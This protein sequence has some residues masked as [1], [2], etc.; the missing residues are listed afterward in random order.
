MSEYNMI[1]GYDPF[2]TGE[3]I[4]QLPPYI[5]YVKLDDA[6]RITSVNSS[7]FLSDTTGWTEVLLP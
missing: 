6:S 3:P 2:Y 5:V 1:D 7:S 4:K